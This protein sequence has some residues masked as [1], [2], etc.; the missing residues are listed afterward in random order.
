[1]LMNR[2]KKNKKHLAKHDLFLIYKFIITQVWHQRGNYKYT[3]TLSAQNIKVA[4]DLVRPTTDRI[5]FQQISSVIRGVRNINKVDILSSPPDK[6]C[7]S[8]YGKCEGQ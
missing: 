1:M 3:W 4:L 2:G 7:L 8:K 5:K 6:T